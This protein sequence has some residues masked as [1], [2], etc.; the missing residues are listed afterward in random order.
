M[1]E[2]ETLSSAYNIISEFGGCGTQACVGRPGILSKENGIQWSE[3]L[4]VW[5]R[6]GG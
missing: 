6:Q 1:A 3:D 4:Q 2:E 5:K